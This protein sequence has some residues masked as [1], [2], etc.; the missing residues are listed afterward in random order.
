MRV[1]TIR[2][3]LLC[4]TLMLSAR[5]W[6]APQAELWPMWQTHNPDSVGAVSH[7]GFDRFLATYLKRSADGVY[8]VQY[9][10]VS[11]ASRAGLEDYLSR[12]QAVPIRK[13]SR[14]QQYAYWVNLYNAKTVQL[15][16]EHQ[17]KTSIRNIKL[18]GLFR[19]GPWDAKVLKVEG[20]ELSLNDIEHRI[21]RPIWRDPRSHYALNCASI[22]CPNLQP[23]AWDA[24]TLETQLEAA[25]KA[26]V[27]HPRAVRVSGD[28]L[29]VSSIYVWFKSDFGGSDAGVIA[30]L[31]RYAEPALAAKLGA[32]KK[33]N[34]DGYDWAL[35]GV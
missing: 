30:H 10:G 2:Y 25:A 7:E 17:E 19:S 26:F 34:D 1:P 4:F 5:A 8:R 35:N 29:W 11:A 3:L 20:T 6:A 24:S 14:P 27:N 31:K 23:R 9:A 18:G 16:L 13:Y 21:L 33:I 12:L 28:K 32:V 15:V 22:G